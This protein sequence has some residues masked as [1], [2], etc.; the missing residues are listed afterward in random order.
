MDRLRIEIENL[1][2]NVETRFQYTEQSTKKHMESM[3]VVIQRAL[4]ACGRC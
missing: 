2:R 1:S 3:G 4:R